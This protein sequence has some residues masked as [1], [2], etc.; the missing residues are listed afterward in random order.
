MQRKTPGQKQT[1]VLTELHIMS[2]T[3]LLDVS[4]NEEEVGDSTSGGVMYGIMQKSELFQQL[5]YSWLLF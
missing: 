3:N 5:Y 4:G 2:K 1:L